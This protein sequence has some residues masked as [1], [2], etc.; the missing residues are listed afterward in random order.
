MVV[1]GTICSLL[2]GFSIF[3]INIVFDEGGTGNI[4]NIGSEDIRDFLKKVVLLLK[5]VGQKV[6]LGKVQ[7]MHTD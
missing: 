3:R 4:S 5:L 1:A 7:I 6:A 2:D